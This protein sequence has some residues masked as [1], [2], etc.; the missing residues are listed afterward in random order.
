MDKALQKRYLYCLQTDIRNP[1]LDY[2]H[3]LVKRHLHTIP[4]ENLSKFHY[5]VNHGKTGFRWLPSMDTY[6]NHVEQER[7]GGNCY[8]LNLHFGRLLQS[9][10]FQVEVVRATSGNA[11]LANKVTVEGRSYY[12]DVGYG[13][14][15]FEPLDLEEQPRFS[16]RGEEVEIVR[17]DTG[18][19]VIDRRMNGQSFVTKC[20]EWTPV[21]IES[22]EPDITHSLRDEEDNPFMRRIVATLFKPDAAYSVINQ[23]LII[24][25]DDGTEIHECARK[26]DWI[27]MME[28][29]FGFQ[30]EMLNQALRF[31]ADRGNRLFSEG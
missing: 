29:T 4:F 9:L 20:I 2:L 25:T 1:T 10:G 13:A 30:A 15:L 23:K 5:Y 14:P 8:I 18:R 12:V 24:K 31:V 22:F 6:L 16:R 19:Y 7:L 28:K 21:E 11:H 27:V 3:V 17:L 26:Q